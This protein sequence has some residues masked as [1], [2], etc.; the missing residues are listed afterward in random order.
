MQK[1]A[2]TRWE[3][4][5]DATAD[6]F[7]V[8]QL[9]PSCKQYHV[10]QTDSAEGEAWR[11]IAYCGRLHIESEG[12]NAYTARYCLAPDGVFN[13]GA[14][15]EASATSAEAAIDELKFKLS[16]ALTIFNFDLEAMKPA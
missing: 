2:V 15:L 5:E 1:E 9:M 3:E 13:P 6:A 12:A 8:M 4:R 14:F 16:A 7:R 10:D 11:Y